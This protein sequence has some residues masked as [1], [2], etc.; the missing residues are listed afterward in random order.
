MQIEEINQLLAQLTRIAEAFEEQNRINVEWM[1]YIKEKD[2]KD[3]QRAKKF[4]KDLLDF[5]SVRQTKMMQTIDTLCERT[6]VDKPDWWDM[7]EKSQDH[8]VR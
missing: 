1:G 6:A 8:A 7:E 4:T 2:D 5:L 3:L